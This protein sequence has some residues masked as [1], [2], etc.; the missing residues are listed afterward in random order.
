[1][2]C[3]WYAGDGLGGRNNRMSAWQSK[4]IFHCVAS[5]T[6]PTTVGKVERLREATYKV[7]TV[8][9]AYLCFGYNLEASAT[10]CASLPTNT[11]LDFSHLVLQCIAWGVEAMK[12]TGRC[13]NPILIIG[14]CVWVIDGGTCTQIRSSISLGTE[15][16]SHCW[17]V[18]NIIGRL[19]ILFLSKLSFSSS[20]SASWA[21]ILFH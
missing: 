5:L 1:M 18:S 8:C 6:S 2:D 7:C 9:D 15:G 4:D 14:F 17:H 12:K 16:V 3:T 21:S 11:T 10:S 13:R 19:I 20:S